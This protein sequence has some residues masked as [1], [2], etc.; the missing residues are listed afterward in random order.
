MK[1]PFRITSYRSGT[2]LIRDARKTWKK[3]NIQEIEN[4]LQEVSQ[5]LNDPLL[6]QFLKWKYGPE[7]I[8]ERGGQTYASAIFKASQGQMDNLESVLNSDL[9]IRVPAEDELISQDASY[10]ALLEKIGRPPAEEPTYSMVDI[11][12][13]G[14][15][16]MSSELGTVFRAVD[17]CESLAW[18]L[19]WSWDDN[20]IADETQ[21]DRLLTHLPLRR[22]LH[23][24][25]DNPLINGRGRSAAIGIST[26]VAFPID[27]QIFLWLKKGSSQ[28]ISLHSS[29]LR[30]IPAGLFQPDTEDVEQEFSVRHNFY[31]VYLE[32]VFGRREDGVPANSQSFY[33]D[34]ALD[35]LR[36]LLESGEASLKFTGIA[37]NL[38]NLR[39]EICTLLYIKTPDWY[40]FHSESPEESLRFNFK[41]ESTNIFEELDALDSFVGMIPFQ[42]SD[43]TLFASGKLT[44]SRLT[45]PGAAA[46]WMG[47]DAL[48]TI[49]G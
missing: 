13:E 16:Q 6:Y 20:L 27:D 28:G 11:D 15:L 44:P 1:L 47:V 10:R 45:P 12:V 43:E 29:L 46:F 36:K 37:M 42:D 25:I 30:A 2:E 33:D 35:Y 24:E 5:A 34:P 3:H 9:D 49:L 32:E 22:K 8:L 40:K 4:R 48:R 14:G 38:L 31:R 19:L 23:E 18:E 26:L 21:F 7:Y 17:T 41:D 39:P